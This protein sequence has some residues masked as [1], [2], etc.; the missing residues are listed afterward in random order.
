MAPRDGLVLPLLSWSAPLTF[1][2]SLAAA[3]FKSWYSFPSTSLHS[4]AISFSA[5]DFSLPS[6][7]L[8]SI[9][10]DFSHSSSSSLATFF[11][12]FSEGLSLPTIEQLNSPE[13][14]LSMTIVPFFPSSKIFIFVSVSSI[15]L[16]VLTF[17][18]PAIEESSASPLVISTDL[19]SPVKDSLYL[20]LNFPTAELQI[21]AFLTFFS[22]VVSCTK[23]GSAKATQ[24]MHKSIIDKICFFTYSPYTTIVLSV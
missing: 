14:F 22:V 19:F 11:L 7:V 13:G 15:N 2:A 18:S 24:H 17:L 12:G 1:L 23:M 3:R 6:C 21:S 8:R 16:E 9:G 5:T 4:F 20:L 10:E